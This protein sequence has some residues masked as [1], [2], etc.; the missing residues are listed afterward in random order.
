MCCASCPL[1]CGVFHFGATQAVWCM[2]P[3]CLAS[4]SCSSVGVLIV[5]ACLACDF[6]RCHAV[7]GLVCAR[8]RVVACDL[9]DTDG[10]LHALNAS[11]GNPLWFLSA[12]DA[13]GTYGIYYLPA[14]DNSRTGVGYIA[15]GPH[16]V[17]FSVDT[18][19][20]YS[21]FL[22][23]PTDT[24][25]S[26]VMLTHDGTAL[27]VTVRPCFV[28]VVVVQVLVVVVAV[29]VVVVVRLLLF[30]CCCV[31]WC[32]FWASASWA[33]VS[34]V[35]VMS[36]SSVC[37][38]RCPRLRLALHRCTS[39]SVRDIV[40]DDWLRVSPHVLSDCRARRAPCGA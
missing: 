17:A 4:L 37:I 11:D 33:L 39:P 40:L 16:V 30:G 5:C 10:M 24:F 18:G 27:F 8:W 35:C 1:P 13:N 29:V 15:Y 26:S 6:R 7:D 32:F 34:C 14:V 2:S 38:L 22:G 36:C 9:Q 12:R 20:V 31:S 23:D 25:K 21:R 3:C 19:V 28:R